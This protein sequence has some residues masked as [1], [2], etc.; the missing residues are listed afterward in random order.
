MISAGS[1]HKHRVQ[2]V[3]YGLSAAAA[4]SIVLIL[5]P[6]NDAVRIAKVGPLVAVVLL[7]VAVVGV[8]GAR[9]GQTALYLAA[10][11]LAV[12]A[13]FLQLVQF[14]RTPNW[15]EGNGSTAALLVGLGIGFL[16][17]WYAARAPRNSDQPLPK[18]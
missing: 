10:G 1:T 17:L 13:G 6:G 16:A 2:R 9:M 12:A 18:P 8:L 4:L 11:G 14:G 3:G 15:L 7:L 5:A